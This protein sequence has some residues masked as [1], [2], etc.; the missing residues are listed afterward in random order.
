MKSKIT[1]ILILAGLLALSLQAFWTLPVSAS[2][3]D[4][5]TNPAGPQPA[6]SNTQIILVAPADTELGS[7]FTLIGA[8]KDQSGAGIPDKSIIFSIF[9]EYLT[10]TRTLADGTFNFQVNKDLAAGSYWLTATFN[11][12]H[13]MDPSSAN[14]VLNIKPA[15]V[16]VQTVPATAGIKFKMDERTFVTAENGLASV[17]IY[18]VGT[19]RLEVLIDEYQA[20]D[21]Q[22]KF[23]RWSEES[24]IP[25]R[26]V[27][28]PGNEVVQVGLNTFHQ[29]RQTFVDLDG[30]P[31]DP[32]RISGITI[33]SAQGDV[34]NFTSP[35]SAWIPSSRTARREQGLEE[36]KLQYS[37]L[38]VMIDGSNV[39]NQAQQRFY[40]NPNDNWTISLILYTLHIDARDGLFGSPVGKSVNLQYPD[41]HIKNYPLD[42]SGSIDIHSLAR[43]IYHVE[44]VGTNGMNSKIP[45]A[46]SRNQELS[47]K[48]ITYVDMALVAGIT[49]AF[50]IGL[51]LYGRPWLLHFFIKKKDRAI[52]P[53][54]R[55]TSL[56][57]N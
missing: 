25:A 13:L 15:K 31:V 54:Q 57:E 50:A 3:L 14:T 46:L 48:V 7:P 36:T 33:K 35:Q 53:E 37:V 6:A 49:A 16:V 56:H 51:L 4:P 5:Q 17:Q 29:V 2:P 34:F 32:S 21:K 11:G 40:A 23:G 42:K 1:S 55:W 45:V 26:D 52:T 27:R 8:L 30:Y 44:L 19:Y 24:Y 20:P 43:G 47:V 10:Q 18:K 28:V 22:V 38:S 12:A 39:V 41:G 9:G